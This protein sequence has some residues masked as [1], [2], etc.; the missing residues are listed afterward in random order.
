MH[1][2]WQMKAVIPKETSW[3]NESWGCERVEGVKLV[4]N[5]RVLCVETTLIE[6]NSSIKVIKNVLEEVRVL[7]I[8][9]ITEKLLINP[10]RN[11]LKVLFLERFTSVPHKNL[12]LFSEL[13]IKDQYNKLMSN[14][15][16][17]PHKIQ[18]LIFPLNQVTII[19]PI[20]HVISIQLNQVLNF[21][22][23]VSNII[24]FWDILT[25]S[26]YFERCWWLHCDSLS[27]FSNSFNIN[28]GL[29]LG[30]WC[31]LKEFRCFAGAIKSIDQI[32]I[33]VFDSHKLHPIDRIIFSSTD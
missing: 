29:I 13:S 5:K 16:I 22:H 31:D 3:K 25:E 2:N 32:M 8:G 20:L 6:G 4:L 21:I 27:L 15:I 1:C 30:L 17:H 18:L 28:F 23:R 14:P 10:F 24:C 9:L 7:W 33:C 12:T 11:S 26:K 19:F